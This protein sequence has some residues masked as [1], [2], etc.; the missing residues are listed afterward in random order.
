MRC[1]LC[2]EGALVCAC[3]EQQVTVG[4]Y[5]HVKHKALKRE[6]QVRRQLAQTQLPSGINLLATEV[7][8]ILVVPRQLLRTQHVSLQTQLRLEACKQ[9]IM[10]LDLRP[11]QIIGVWLQ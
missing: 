7:T 10:M 11:Q 6:A 3:S 4:A 1:N 8:V 5:L 9:L 2:L